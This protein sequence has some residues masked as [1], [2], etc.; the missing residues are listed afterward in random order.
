MVSR[1]TGSVKYQLSSTKPSSAASSAG[2]S[3]PTRATSTAAASSS[4]SASGSCPG[5]STRVSTAVRSTGSSRALSQPA[6]W[7]ERESG[8][9]SGRPCSRRPTWSWVTRCTSMAPASEAIRSPLEPTSSR[10]S[11]PWRLTP[12]TTMVALAPEAKSTTAAGTSSPTTGWKLP[13]RSATSCWT[14]AIGS[15]PCGRSPSVASTCT[16]ISSEPAARWASRAPR[17]SRVSLSGP[18][19]TATTIRSLVG[20]VCAMRWARR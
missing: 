14:R 6:T 11:R 16:A 8:E 20:Q 3:P 19:V 17:R 13:P 10:R 4:I 9:S 7:R 5:P 12:T 15:P 2:S 18:P 1:P